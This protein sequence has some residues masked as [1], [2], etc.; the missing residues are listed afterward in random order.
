MRNNLIDLLI[1]TARSV[2]LAALAVLLAIASASA[3]DSSASLDADGLQFTYN[4]DIKVESEDL[5]LSLEEVR[6]AYRFHNTS[7]RDISTLVAF[8]RMSARKAITCSR[9]TVIRSTS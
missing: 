8:P 6:V 9:R 5:S 3:N 7:D 1:N 2:G 4:P